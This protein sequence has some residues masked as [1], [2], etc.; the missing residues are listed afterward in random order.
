MTNR[1]ETQF[2]VSSCL[3]N[4][5]DGDTVDIRFNPANPGEF[6]LPGLIQSRLAKA[7][8]LTIFAV[9][10]IL[11]LIGIALAWFGPT[12]SRRSRIESQI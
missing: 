6:Y 12:F 7:W 4:R 9:L 11:I 1:K 10:F 5:P 2:W 8:K 3:A